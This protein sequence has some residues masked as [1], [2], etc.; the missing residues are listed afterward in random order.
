MDFFKIQKLNKSILIYDLGGDTFDVLILS[1]KKYEKNP[2][3]KIFLFLGTSG[4]MKFGV[5]DFDNQ[6]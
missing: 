5:K 2:N 6:L 3:S 1:I 4:D